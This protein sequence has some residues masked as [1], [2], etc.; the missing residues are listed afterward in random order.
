[1]LWLIVNQSSLSRAS[2]I[3]W[4]RVL[5][6]TALCGRKEWNSTRCQL[7]FYELSGLISVLYTD[8]ILF[9]L[10][11]IRHY[12][13]GMK[14]NESQHHQ[15]KIQSILIPNM[16]HT[17]GL[18]QCRYVTCG[19]DHINLCYTWCNVTLTMSTA[20]AEQQSSTL[21]TLTPPQCSKLTGLSCSLQTTLRQTAN[22]QLLC[23]LM[24]VELIEVT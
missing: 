21:F 13:A 7:M 17:D 14:V 12:T 20:A 8:S 15:L 6:L 24:V 10:S 18:S 22:K 2:V 1:M 4:S 16:W 5:L 3:S 9:I 23:L 19:D 11:Y